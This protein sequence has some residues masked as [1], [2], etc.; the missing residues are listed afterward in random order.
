VP[1]PTLIT[2][3]APSLGQARVSSRQ[4]NL[5]GSDRSGLVDHGGSGDRTPKPDACAVVPIRRDPACAFGVVPARCSALAA[6]EPTAE[7]APVSGSSAIGSA[8][9]GTSSKR[10][11]AMGSVT[12]DEHVLQGVEL[13]EALTAPDGDA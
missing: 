11:A 12:R 1:H 5:T 6:R 7:C 9:N 8:R 10:G 2:S 13:L 3:G 4:Q